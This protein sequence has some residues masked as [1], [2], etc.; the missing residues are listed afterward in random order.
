MVSPP[1]SERVTAPIAAEIAD[2]AGI[3]WRPAI[4][5][6]LDAIAVVVRE[7]GLV[8]HPNYVESKEE[9][10]EILTFS[11]IDHS[12]DTRVAVDVDGTIVAYGVVELS[13]AAE[14]F[15]RSTLHGGV[16]PHARG[17]GIGRELLA[18]Q[19]QRAL[20]QLASSE[21]TLPGWIQLYADDRAAASVRLIER[22]GFKAVRWFR[23]MD[24]LLDEDIPSIALAHGLELRQLSPELAEQA[25]IAKNDS[26]RDHWGSQSTPREAWDAMM[27]MEVMRFDLSWVAVDG[28]RIAGLVLTFVNEDDWELAGYSSGYIGLVGVIRD[29]R[30]KGIAP[31]LLATAMQSFRQAGLERA[32][33]DVDSENPS[34]ADS[35]YTGMG[36]FET[37]RSMAFTKVF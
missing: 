37:T 27:A 3:S 18:W 23:G 8:D 32:C 12:R 36:F 34:G 30:R 16:A 17:R 15:V 9:V 10:E 28:D 24:R 11:W 25:W 7:I 6:D 19:E 22:A 1:L 14:D 31:A 20:Q 4:A 35:L 33:L 26:F 13:P 5:D 2:V 21:L 29:W